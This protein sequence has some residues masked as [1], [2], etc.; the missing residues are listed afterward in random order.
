MYE[1]GSDANTKRNAN[2]N[3]NIP[4]DNTITRDSVNNT[5]NKGILEKKIS[6]RE[7]TIHKPFV[8]ENLTDSSSNLGKT[9]LDRKNNPYRSSDAINDREKFDIIEKNIPKQVYRY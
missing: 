9:I 5:N 7:N 8:N 2:S 6:E 3:F 4:T 1:V